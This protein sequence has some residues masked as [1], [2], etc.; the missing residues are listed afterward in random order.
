[1]LR[2]IFLLFFCCCSVASASNLNIQPS[3]RFNNDYIF[4]TEIYLNFFYSLGD[5]MSLNGYI[6]KSNINGDVVTNIVDH[7]L[8]V[9]PTDLQ[10]DN[11]NYF[12]NIAFSNRLYAR[13]N[14]KIMYTLSW[15]DNIKYNHALEYT[16]AYIYNYLQLKLDYITDFNEMPLDVF[17]AFAKSFDNV[18]DNISIGFNT[19]YK[20]A[21][22][23]V[24]LFQYTYTK[25]IKSDNEKIIDRHYERYIIQT[26]Y[27]LYEAHVISLVDSLTLSD[28][29]NIDI[30]L[31][32]SMA[33]NFD[34]NFYFGVGYRF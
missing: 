32:Y 29:V 34:N 4:S 19:K 28:V 14:Y 11:N 25:D 17:V 27:L 2:K 21:D 12:Y 30:L 7:H 31:Q 3:I 24:L 23:N 1:M 10:T 15:Y 5:D 9:K 18:K 6:K 22:N 13:D 20:I 26:D 8:P 16:Y 33:K